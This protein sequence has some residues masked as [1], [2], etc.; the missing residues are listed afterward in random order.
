MDPFREEL[1][2]W[3]ISPEGKCCYRFHG[4]PK[5][6]PRY[7]QVFVDKWT[8]QPD[9]SPYRMKQ[10]SKLPLDEALQMCGEMLIAGWRKLSNQFKELPSVY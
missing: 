4:D 2:A 6:W 1:N 3:L 8:T 10:R 5:S 9:G 7:S